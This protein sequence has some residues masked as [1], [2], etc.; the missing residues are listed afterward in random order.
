MYGLLAGFADGVKRVRKRRHFCRCSGLSASAATTERGRQLSVG[1]RWVI[2][3]AIDLLAAN[4][5]ARSRQQQT[6]SPQQVPRLHHSCCAGSRSVTIATLLLW[7]RKRRRFVSRVIMKLSSKVLRMTRVK[8]IAQF[9]LP[10]TRLS[11]NGM[12]HPAF[13]PQP[14]SIT[15]IWSVLISRPAEDR[16]LSWPRLL[17]EVICPPEDDYSSQYQPTNSAAAGDRTHDHWVTSPTP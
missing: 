2:A 14:Q 13:T 1:C 6:V 10:P 4:W 3:A 7:Y 8:G 15:T 12:S 9:C 16:R 5:A 17:T 11:T